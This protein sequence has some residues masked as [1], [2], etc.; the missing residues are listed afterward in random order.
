MKLN[1]KTY[2]IKEIKGSTV[3]MAQITFDGIFVIKNIRIIEGSHGLFASF[4]SLKNKHGEW[5]EVA[6]PITKEA[7]SAINKAIV[8]DFEKRYPDYKSKENPGNGGFISVD[9]GEEL[10]IH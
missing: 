2:L 8:G 6:F 1:V 10:P 5:E 9:T 4:P 3:G 7:A